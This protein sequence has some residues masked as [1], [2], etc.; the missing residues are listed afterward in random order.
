MDRRHRG[1][2]VSF[3][4]LAV[5][6]PA[7]SACC[8]GV[9]TDPRRGGLAG[10]VCGTTTGAYEG[11]LQTRRDE[12]ASLDDARSRLERH[13]ASTRATADDLG[14]DVAAATR[15]AEA[16]RASVAATEAEIA[17]LRARKSVSEA[18]LA[19]LEAENAQLG[20]EVGQLMERARRTE[21]AA[22]ALREG[23][24]A[25]AD[26]SAIRAAEA[27]DRSRGEDLDRR[28]AD[29]RRRVSRAESP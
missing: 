9:D 14:R 29:L 15:R 23:A 28:L 17:R 1:S 18:E 6:A 2:F 16:R 7:L 11:R 26:E 5:I 13:L 4:A 3:A 24:V 19:A 12:L 25:A 10:G 21:T 22:R 8:N 27:R 20:A